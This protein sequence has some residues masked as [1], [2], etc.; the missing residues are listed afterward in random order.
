MSNFKGQQVI[1]SIIEQN[2][3]VESITANKYQPEQVLDLVEGLSTDRINV[4]RLLVAGGVENVGQTISLEVAPMVLPLRYVN[5]YKKLIRPESEIEP[6][7]L[8]IFES[9]NI[10][11]SK[12][13][14]EQLGSLEEFNNERKVRIGEIKDLIKLRFE[15]DSLN[16][17][18]Q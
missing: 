18:N 10:S 12:M 15:D 14:I 5:E 1:E 16:E 3:P 17:Q 9:E 8:L 7:V 13:K 2:Y 4:S 11:K 6:Q